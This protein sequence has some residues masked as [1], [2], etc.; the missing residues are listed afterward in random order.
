VL[1]TLGADLV[2]NIRRNFRGVS[3]PFLKK[4]GVLRDVANF[5]MLTL[6]RSFHTFRHVNAGLGTKS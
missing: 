2:T 5:D 3:S 6:W 4:S 1:F